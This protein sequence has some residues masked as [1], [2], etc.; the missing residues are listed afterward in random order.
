MEAFSSYELQVTSHADVK[1]LTHVIPLTILTIRVAVE[2]L[3]RSAFPLWFSPGGEGMKRGTLESMNDIITSF[4]DPHG[5]HGRISSIESS[6]EAM[7]AASKLQHSPVKSKVDRFSSTSKL[8]RTV[9][10][11]PSHGQ[12]R[13]LLKSRNVDK[14]PSPLRKHE[15]KK[16]NV[17]A[18]P[19][20]H[21]VK[22]YKLAVEKARCGGR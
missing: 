11:H 14:L 9:I 17:D 16:D 21:R 18:I 6:N 5:Y 4:L 13:N 7:R 19:V 12:V 22:L 20:E 10:S 2:E 3:F 15:G 8:L 1:A